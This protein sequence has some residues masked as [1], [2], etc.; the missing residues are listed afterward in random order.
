MDEE[1]KTY[2]QGMEERLVERMREMQRELVSEFE[3][4]SAGQTVRLRKLEEDQSNLEYLAQKR[5]CP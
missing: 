3:S 5:R 4:F 1:L 2:L